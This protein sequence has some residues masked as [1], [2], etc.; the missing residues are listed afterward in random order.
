MLIT[1]VSFCQCWLRI[2]KHLLTAHLCHASTQHQHGASASPA[3]FVWP[4]ESRISP[5][6]ALCRRGS[7]RAV[8]WRPSAWPSV[9]SPVQ[10]SVRS[11]RCWARLPVDRRAAKVLHQRE[12][13]VA[14]GGARAVQVHCGW[15]AH[16]R[17][18]CR[19]AGRDP[20]GKVE[21]WREGAQR[22]AI[23]YQPARS[24]G[25]QILIVLLLFY[26][27]FVL[28]YVIFCCFMLLSFIFHVNLLFPRVSIMNH[29][30]SICVN[31]DQHFYHFLCHFCVI[32]CHFLSLFLTFPLTPFSRNNFIA[33]LSASAAPSTIT[34][35][36]VTC[37][38]ASPPPN[39]SASRT[40]HCPNWASILTILSIGD[41]RRPNMIGRWSAV[42][43]RKVS[44]NDDWW[45]RKVCIDIFVIYIQYYMLI[46][47]SFLFMCNL[48]KVCIM[49][50]H[51]LKR[52]LKIKKE[53]KRDICSI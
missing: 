47:H 45:R 9:A 1:K 49:I 6:A 19:Y 2:S 42:V 25:T 48:E 46:M 39:H 10:Q 29:F 44:L 26:A 51:D 31:F 53:Q 30:V 7:P 52:V 22:D 20:Y 14:E 4:V 8:C 35:F 21:W 50:W 11:G 32:L 17:G 12:R 23:N 36:K 5:H 13:R 18:W 33:P 28:F 37:S 27:L 24:T 15:R 43:S 41:A 40:Q 38:A 34:H 3:S 16:H